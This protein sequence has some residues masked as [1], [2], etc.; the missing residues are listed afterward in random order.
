MGK[1]G[2]G[3]LTAQCVGGQLHVAQPL[4]VS[5]GQVM[6]IAEFT[7]Q[8][9]G[10]EKGQEQQRRQGSRHHRVSFRAPSGAPVN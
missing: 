7:P 6:D 2:R 10:I 5:G 8:S 9:G 4:E 1:H 3:L